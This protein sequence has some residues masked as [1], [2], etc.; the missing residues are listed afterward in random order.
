MPHSGIV[1]HFQDPE[2]E[3]RQVLS[4]CALDAYRFNISFTSCG[5]IHH[6]VA[7]NPPARTLTTNNNFS[8]SFSVSGESPSAWFRHWVSV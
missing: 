3:T 6:P 7:F 1:E 4:L 8:S 5:A 2:R